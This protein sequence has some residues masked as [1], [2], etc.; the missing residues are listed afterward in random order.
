MPDFHVVAANLI[1][2]E[3]EYLLVK[4]GKEPVRGLW[5]LPAG[6]AKK[7]E[8]IKEAAVREVKEE[9]GLKVSLEGILGV[10]VDESDRSD[11]KVLIFVFNASTEDFEI[12]TPESGEILDA[13][14]YS[15]DEIN[16]MDIRVPFIQEAI[17]RYERGEEKSLDTLKD[18]RK[19]LK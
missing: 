15:S 19:D 7:D 8:D 17:K 6:G 9:T 3:G 10:F 4:E 5:N 11:T 14:L 16:S 2:K 1:E 12:K 13:G 18:Y